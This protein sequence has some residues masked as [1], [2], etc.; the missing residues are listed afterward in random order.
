M[1]F[2]RAARRS[3]GSATMP[4]ARSHVERGAFCGYLARTAGPARPPQIWR[5][6]WRRRPGSCV[7]WGARPLLP[8]CP[9]WCWERTA[10]VVVRWGPILSAPNPL[11]PPHRRP[12]PRLW[13]AARRHCRPPSEPHPP[14]GAAPQS[15]AWARR[16]RRSF[17]AP[18]RHNPGPRAA[19]QRPASCP[20]QRS[21]SSSGYPGIA[22]E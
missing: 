3:G 1:H 21:G 22:Y 15:T 2:F 20:G 12:A 6:W 18:R 16:L 10:D 5:R 14:G 7:F 11:V 8:S 9:D 4:P 13:T 17:T 19:R